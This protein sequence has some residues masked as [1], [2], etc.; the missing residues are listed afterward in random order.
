[1]VELP[2]S[3]RAH[4]ILLYR[5]G[6]PTLSCTRVFQGLTITRRDVNRA[7]HPYNTKGGAPC[8]VDWTAREL[9]RCADAM[10]GV[11][12]ISDFEG[13]ATRRTYQSYDSLFHPGTRGEDRR[14]HFQA[15]GRQKHIRGH[16]E[17]VHSEQNAPTL[18]SQ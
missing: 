18:Q 12:H 3:R 8:G 14:A 13:W 7:S 17:A 15:R 2:K 1:M 6:S 16:G 5:G 9:Q 4:F 10:R 11:G